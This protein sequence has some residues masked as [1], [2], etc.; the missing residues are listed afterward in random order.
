MS[1]T[2]AEL[3]K[4]QYAVG[5]FTEMG[6]GCEQ[7]PFEANA[8]YVRAADQGDIRA[9][10]RISTIRAANGFDVDEGP[11]KGKKRT[12]MPLSAS[13]RNHMLMLIRADEHRAKWLGIF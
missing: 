8:W 5:F 6:L 2:S 9:R 11:A 1:L 10:Q 4:A 7:D 12:G 13:F 3:P